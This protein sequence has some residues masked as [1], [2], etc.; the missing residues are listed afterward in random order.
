MKLDVVLPDDLAT[1]A[2]AAKTAEDVGYAAGWA[3]EI[4]H[5]ALQALT[6]AAPGTDRLQLGTGI[7]VAFARSPMV[8]AIAAN[9][10]Q[11]VSRGRLLLGLGSQV[12]AHITHRFS[13]PWSSPAPRMREYISA[14]H[15]IWATWNE[16]APLAFRGDFYTHTVTSPVFTPEPNPYG[17]PKVFLAAVGPMMTEVAGEVADGLICHSFTTERYVREVTLPALTRGRERA[18]RSAD[19]IEL[20][21][22]PFIVTGTTEAEFD[23][24]RATAKQ[25]IAFYGSTPSYRAVLELHGWGELQTALWQLTKDGR[26]SEM[27]DLIDDDVLAAFAIVAEPD[28]LATAIESRFGDIADRVCLTTSEDNQAAID[29]ARTALLAP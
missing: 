2:G 9:D 16:G 7:A 19:A 8:T 25:R 27:S 21:L 10:L 23:R 26:W 12:R 4:R 13:M 17:P 1:M 28:Q 20:S 15:A 5:D 3:A 22:A 29:A 11:L 14:L 18:D 6:L 24:A